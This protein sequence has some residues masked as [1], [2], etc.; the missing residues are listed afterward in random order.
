MKPVQIALFAVLLALG[1]VIAYL[2]MRNRQP[3]VLPADADHATFVNA[4]TSNKRLLLSRVAFWGDGPL[5]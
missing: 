2:A 4:V 5:A 3:P 1:L